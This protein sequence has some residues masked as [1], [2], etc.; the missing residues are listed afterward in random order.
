MARQ[1]HSIGFP[2]LSEPEIPLYAGDMVTDLQIVSRNRLAETITGGLSFPSKMPCPAWGISAAR[3]RVGQALARTVG[4]TCHSCYAMRGTYTF[5]SVQAKLEQRYRGLFHPL[6]T[7]AMVFLI[8]YYCDR[9]FRLFDSGDLIGENHLRNIITIARHTPEVSIWLPTRE[10]QVVRTCAEEIPPNLT[11]RVSAHQV[12]GE[13]PSWWPT[14]S[15]V[16]SEQEAG[17]GVCP[18]L[19]QDNHCDECRACWSKEIRNVAYRLH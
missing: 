18:A 10:Y 15:T 6:W 13:A 17:E 12:D 3:C 1:R 7:P 5:A 2:V 4:T 9:Y 14:S 11:V 8:N 19:D 16:T